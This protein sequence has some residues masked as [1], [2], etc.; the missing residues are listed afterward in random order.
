MPLL[1]LAQD[2]SGAEQSAQFSL[3]GS[4]AWRSSLSCSDDDAEKDADDAE[5]DAEDAEKDA[6]EDAVEDDIL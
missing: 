4:A 5:E 3:P 2:G 1:T 6:E